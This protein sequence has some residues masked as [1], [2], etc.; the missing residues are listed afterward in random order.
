MPEPYLQSMAVFAIVALLT[1]VMLG[2]LDLGLAD[3]R[4]GVLIGGLM[5][6]L[7]LLL[8]IEQSNAWEKPQLMQRT[9]NG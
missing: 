8:N 5:G 4:I 2:A 3:F 7:G 1:C 6:L 9:A